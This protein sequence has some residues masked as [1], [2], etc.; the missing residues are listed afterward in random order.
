MATP[1]LLIHGLARFDILWNAL[2][3]IDTTTS[4]F[5]DRFHYFKGIRTALIREGFPAYCAHLSWAGSVDRR[6]QQ[7]KKTVIRILN[8][9][10]APRI[11]LI[12][13]SMG[14]LDARHMMFN[15]RKK[16]QIHQKIASLTTLSTPHDG[17]TYADH[18]LQRLAWPYRLLRAMSID[19]RGLED[20]GT[21]ACQAY[22]QQPDVQSFEEACERT[23]LFQ[24]YA[25]RQSYQA[26]SL[27]HRGAYPLIYRREGDN[28]GMVSVRSA[29]WRP[30]YFKGILDHMEHFNLVGWISP[31]QILRGTKPRSFFKIIQDFYLDLAKSL[32]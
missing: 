2:L 28:D 11:H 9:T 26:I 5:L 30:R 6:A 29:Q 32:P 27:L 3:G 21:R 31:D 24:T 4:P 7:L 12:A 25:G 1:I 19:V 17:A 13:H 23:I 16:D 8:E 18:L 15:D 22:N 20:V 14:G 10:G